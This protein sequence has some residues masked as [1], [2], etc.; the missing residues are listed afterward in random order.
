L[1]EKARKSY[2]GIARNTENLDVLMQQF[3]VVPDELLC[4]I[5]VKLSETLPQSRDAKKK[6]VQAGLLTRM[7]SFVVEPQSELAQSLA[8]VKSIFPEDVLELYAPTSQS[9]ESPKF[10]TS[11]GM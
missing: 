11:E 7:Q 2:D 10:K 8:A 4:P 6:F 3:Q 9:M 5:L 1:K